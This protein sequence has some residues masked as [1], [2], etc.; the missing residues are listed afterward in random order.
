MGYSSARYEAEKWQGPFDG[1]PDVLTSAADWG[2]LRI[3][4]PVVVKE[5]CTFVTTA[6]VGTTQDGVVAIEQRDAD[7]S[8]NVVELGTV[9]I[10]NTDAVG[11]LHS[12]SLRG[13]SGGGKAVAAG[14][15][16][17]VRCKTALAG[18]TPAGACLWMI[19]HSEQAA[20]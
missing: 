12:V 17:A 15:T 11:A 20:Q 5:L 13:N 7:A 16:L 1:A 18:G 19:I 3:M 2:V 10:H 9:T 6:V 4:K 14:K 8:S